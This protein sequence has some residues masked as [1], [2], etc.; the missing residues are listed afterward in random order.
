[1]YEK[2]SK[3]YGHIVIE[4]DPKLSYLLTM[5]VGNILRVIDDIRTRARSTV[6]QDVVF[7]WEYNLKKSEELGFNLK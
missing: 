1:M 4:R 2:L 3:M 6:T 7:D 5:K